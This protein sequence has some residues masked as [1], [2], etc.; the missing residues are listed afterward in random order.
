M[1]QS[2]TSTSKA[3]YLKLVMEY[4][5]EYGGEN[6]QTLHELWKNKTQEQQ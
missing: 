2:V 5:S 1:D 3:Y 6:K 4:V